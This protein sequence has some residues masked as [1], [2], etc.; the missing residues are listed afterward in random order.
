MV[1]L[2]LIETSNIGGKRKWRKKDLLIKIEEKKK[3]KEEVL[4]AQTA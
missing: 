3:K 4:I 1:D 2:G